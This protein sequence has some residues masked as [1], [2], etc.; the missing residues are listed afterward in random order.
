MLT[1]VLRRS[2]SPVSILLGL[3]LAGCTELSEDPATA[4]DQDAISTENGLASINGLSSF[5]GLATSNGLSSFNG[6]ATSNGLSSF[7]G[8]MTT[9]PGRTTVS[10][11]VKCALPAGHQ[12]TKQDQLGNWYTFQGSLGLGPTWENGGCDETCQQAVSACM[13]AHVNTTGVHIPLWV[14][15]PMA[16][17]GWGS[18]DTFPLP[19]GTFFGNIFHPNSQGV[20]DAFFCNGKG[21]DYSIVPGRLGASQPGSPYRNPYLSSTDQKGYCF[22]HCP[23]PNTQQTAWGS[24]IAACPV[25]GKTF[26]APITVWRGETF[27]AETAA[28]LGG[29]IVD[30]PSCAGGKRVGYINGD[31]KIFPVNVTTTSASHLVIVYYTNGDL[32]S[33]KMTM[34]VGANRQTVSFPPTGSWST[35]GLVKLT[36]AGFILGLNNAVTFSLVPGANPP[37]LD[38]IEIQ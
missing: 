26:A 8:L 13:M 25:N 5:N 24:N 1:A 23:T 12:I 22:D 17:L 14:E 38:W 19:E 11:L 29:R 33:R 36:T 32:V 28:T 16:A 27:Q 9:A 34:S 20:V 31:V 7:N 30:C 18:N 4:V 15:G 35:V 6:L 21:F 37:D 3:G 10:Y 2:L